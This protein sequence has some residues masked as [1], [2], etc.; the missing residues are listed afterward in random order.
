M[1]VFEKGMAGLPVLSSLC[2]DLK[3]AQS[4]VMLTGVGHIHK[5][6]LAHALCSR[7]QRKALFLVA[8][9]AEAVRLCEDLN[10]LGEEAL[11]LPSRELSLRQ[12]DASSREYE[13]QRL[14]VFSRMLKNEYS[15]VVACVDAVFSYT[16][17]PQVL[18]KRTLSLVAGKDVPVENL[19]TALSAAGYERCDQIEG[20][21]QFAVRGGIID[22]YPAQ[23]AAPLRIELWGNTVDTISHF[24]LLSQ[25]RTET[26]EKADIPPGISCLIFMLRQSIQ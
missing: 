15:V 8:D 11:F 14:A 23:N 13:Q 5:A 20:A 2:N 16:V 26:L 17:P 22:V 1:S 24:D 25:R 12:V 3:N 7:L 9:E 19:P 21:G 18:Q 4:P 6:L 10:A